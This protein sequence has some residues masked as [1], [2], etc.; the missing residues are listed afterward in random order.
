MGR[1]A[2]GAT[3]SL[4][5]SLLTLL[6]PAGVLAADPTFER[7]TA[8]QHFGEGISVEQRV[9][10]PSGVQRVE[11]YVRSADGPGTFLA[12][13]PNPG[14]GAQTLRYTD[15]TP[16]GSLMPNTLVELGFRI[17]LA[18]G[19]F[20][21]GPPVRVRYEDDRFDWRTIEGDVVRIHWYQGN[22]GFAERAL[23]IGDK[24]VK[25]AAALLGV[26]ESL[27]IDF[28]VYADRDAFYDVIGPAL[29]E[30][31]GGLAI[32]EIRTLFANIAPS[33][34][35]DPW[36][37]LVV[38]HELT[39]IVFDTATRND[40]HQP[41]H[42]LNEGLADYL[43][44]GYASD[45][46]N[47][48]ERAA[49]SSDLMP[50]HALVL[51]FPSTADR[52]SLG[53][54]ESVS[55]IDYLVRTYG[56]D[57]L[58]ALIQGYAGGVA[59]DDAFQAAL[60]VDV[61]GFEAGW[62]ADLGV[63]EPVPYGPKPAPPGPLPPGWNAAP[64]PSGPPVATPPPPGIDLPG[65]DT[66]LGTTLVIG[67]GVLFAIV[68][69][70]GIFVVARGLNRGD[71]LL[72]HAGAEVPST[73]GRPWSS[74]AGGADEPTAESAPDGELPADLAALDARLAPPPDPSLAPPPP[75]VGESAP[76]DD[77]RLG[78]RP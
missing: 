37:S 40:Y 48:V 30:N 31:V 41:P 73:G 22:Q 1:V 2:L 71:P 19:S 44:V 38:P 68:V 51:R 60:G 56:Q 20:V 34:V 66:G 50:L 57:A 23:S 49:R 8:T 77:D 3:L 74:G 13:I 63:D 69:V 29:Q 21:D 12:Q 11:A 5:V 25:E 42:W 28:Y 18:D 43:A 78:E 67:V 39:H 33:E 62:L 47:N 59:D 36:V 15:E 61:A 32:P 26:D 17:T 45:A 55:A 24:A 76:D 6:A 58:V 72:P 16:P 52:F 54:D 7:A 70:L 9:S 35:A 46:R 10:L 75:P 53:Y 27:P 14:G 4:A 64:Q 65:D